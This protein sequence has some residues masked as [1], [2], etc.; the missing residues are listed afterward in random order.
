MEVEMV[1]QDHR[2]ADGIDSTLYSRWQDT[3]GSATVRC[4]MRR[5]SAR[6][7]KAE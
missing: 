4:R 2:R 3:V 6:R 7:R 1:P 5:V